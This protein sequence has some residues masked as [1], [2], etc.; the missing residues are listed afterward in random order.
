M[1]MK[2][3]AILALSA[4]ATLSA[5]AGHNQFWEQGFLK[6]TPVKDRESLWNPFFLHLSEDY[7]FDEERLYY[8]EHIFMGNY[9]LCPWLN[10]AAGYVYARNRPAHVNPFKTENRYQIDATLFAPEFASL[11]FQCRL[12]MEFRN[13]KGTAMYNRYRVRPR[14]QPTWSFTDFKISPF[15]DN[16][17]F[18]S[19]KHEYDKRDMFDQDRL[20]V[21]V[22]FKP[23]PESMPG[24]SGSLFYQLLYDIRN[25]GHDHRPWNCFCVSMTYSF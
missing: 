14:L 9:R 19:N 2:F 15:L 16:E 1:R 4:F 13:I 12:R 17:F 5:I 20:Q 25:H 7:R 23:M 8:F 6:Y 24:L 11:K 22:T 18:F 3:L 21:G 10:L